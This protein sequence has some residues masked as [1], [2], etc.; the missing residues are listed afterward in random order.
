MSLLELNFPNNITAPLRQTFELAAQKWERVIIGKLPLIQV[1]G[2]V[3]DG[4]IVD[5]RF[6]KIDGP[7]RRLAQAQVI[8]SRPVTF[9]PCYGIIEF[10]VADLNNLGSALHTAILHEMGH[11][12]GIG[13]NWRKKNLLQG[14]GTNDPLFIGNKARVEYGKLRGKSKGMNVPV[15]NET[16]FG[17]QNSHWRELDFGNELMSGVLNPGGNPLSR[18]TIASLQ[19]L[20]Y[21][22]NYNEAEPYQINS[23]NFIA[24]S[25]SNFGESLLEA[26]FCRLLNIDPI[27]LPKSALL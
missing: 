24:K 14:F 20:G 23:N 4:I 1:N 3:T 18:L 10:D 11:L 7:Q 22:V 16:F 13:T 12:L 25:I 5:V 9:F 17:A 2:K 19:D 15:E 27:V 21:E 6:V 26:R 8:N